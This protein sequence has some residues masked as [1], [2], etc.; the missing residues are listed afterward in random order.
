[1]V[2]KK[3]RN[4]EGRTIEKRA[5]GQAGPVGLERELAA[6]N[7]GCLLLKQS[8]L[9]CLLYLF[10]VYRAFVCSCSSCNNDAEK[11]RMYGG[12]HVLG[13]SVVATRRLCR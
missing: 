4:A 11:S 12:Q 8:T 7:A 3:G 2:K 10:C 6:L 1:M 13:V 9:R 5:Y